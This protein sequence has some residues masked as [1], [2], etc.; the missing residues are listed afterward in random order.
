M[1]V[2]HPS[3][4]EKSIYDEARRL[5]S[6]GTT[7]A[8]F[9]SRFFAAGGALAKLSRN[10][11]QRKALVT[12]DLYRWLKER[13]N[14]LRRQEADTFESEVQQASGRLTI[15]VARSLHAALKE[16][17]RYEGVSLS[18]LIR[19]KLSIP[20]KTTARLQLSERKTTSG[21]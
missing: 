17:A 12:S 18:E 20:Y 5:L 10:E 21:A 19:L 11:D 6:E 2:S 4:A 7:A 8:D 15:T 16:E 13:L 3:P 9:S 14:E 1:S